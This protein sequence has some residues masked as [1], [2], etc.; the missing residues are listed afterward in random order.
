MGIVPVR[1]WVPEGRV[2]SKQQDQSP[3]PPF[4]TKEWIKRGVGKM[5]EAEL[6]GIWGRGSDKL[7]TPL[8]KQFR[9]ISGCHV[10]GPT[11]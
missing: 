10:P 11:Q 4:C 9:M 1:V 6:I 2:V 8:I 3:S 7:K 5:G